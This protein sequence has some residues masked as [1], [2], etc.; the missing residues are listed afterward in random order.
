MNLR[1][2]PIAENDDGLETGDSHS[3]VIDGNVF[4]LG[5]PECR[6]G[7]CSKEATL[8]KCCLDYE[9]AA[10]RCEGTHYTNMNICS[11][12]YWIASGLLL[13]ISRHHHNYHL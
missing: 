6:C 7:L 3:L 11:Y 8:S 13:H 10:S 1:N 4:T 5:V 2:D 12:V 9:K